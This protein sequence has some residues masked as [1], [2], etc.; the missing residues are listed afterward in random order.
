MVVSKLLTDDARQLAENWLREWMPAEVRDQLSLGLPEWDDRL[1]VWRV[2]LVPSADPSRPLGEIQIDPDGVINRAP[3]PAMV[4]TRLRELG[5]CPE[6]RNRSGNARIAFPPVPNKV[7]LG[8]SR[9]ALPEFPPNSVQLI[10]TSP[11]YFNA[12]PECAEYVDYPSYLEFLGE[13]FAACHSIL[14]EGRFLVVNVSP[15][16]VRRTSRNTASKRLPIPFDL[17]PILDRIGYEFIDDVIW[18]KPEGAGWHLGRGRRFAADRQPLQ[19]KPVTVTEYVLV[20]RKK[21]DRL[22]DWNLRYHPDPAAVERSLIL[23]EYDKTN[24]WDVTPSNHKAHPA[25]FPD[26]LV[27]KVI[28]YYSFEGDSVLDPFAGTG[29]VG[30]VATAMGRRFVLIEKRIDYFETMRQELSQPGF[31]AG[32]DFDDLQYYWSA[33]DDAESL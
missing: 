6:P 32:V 3:S 11:P 2:A 27:S 1:T 19:Y 26:E 21:T 29:T 7:I 4:G 13:V 30:R 5:K 24:V 18:R 15:V 14:A 23:G 16:L 25:I 9:M 22:I 33:D 31:A 10:F 12:K 20:Y 17:H 8:D 28:R